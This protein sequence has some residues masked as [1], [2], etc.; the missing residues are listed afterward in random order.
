MRRGWLIGSALCLLILVMV[1]A[2]T[3]YFPGDVVAA[4]W[5]QGL[6]PG[7]PGWA[8]VVTTTATFPWYLLLLAAVV[9]LTQRLAGWGI[10]LMSI[11]SFLGMWGLGILMKAWIFRPRPSSDLVEVIGSPSGS[12]FPST[13]ALTYGA[14]FGFLLWV[15][16]RKG[17][18]RGGLGPALFSLFLL[19]AGGTAR[20]VLG[21]H[22]PSDVL[23]SYAIALFW[24]G[25]LFG[26]IDTIR[27]SKR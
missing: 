22:W 9:L 18:R 1:A 6:V 2:R 23:V 4:R 12:A 25:I 20:V 16:L 11:P 27:R 15:S 24:V 8:E 17:L 13:F 3:P 5:I 14:M 19:T 26:I 7:G 21:G 10:G